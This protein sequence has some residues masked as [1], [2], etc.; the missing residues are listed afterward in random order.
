MRC[1]VIVTEAERCHPAIEGMPVIV[2]YMGTYHNYATLIGL[3][4]DN[5]NLDAVY[6]NFVGF[7]IC[8]EVLF[9]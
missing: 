6:Y 7:V 2:F 5:Q 3:Y 1:G 9:Y 8:I 4:I